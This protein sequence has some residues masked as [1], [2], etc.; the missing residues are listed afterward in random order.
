MKI[1]KNGQIIR[2]TE[3]DL[4]RIVKNVLNEGSGMDFMK[5]DELEELGRGI[6]KGLPSCSEIMT[7]M[8]MEDLQQRLDSFK[9]MK[10]RPVGSI[11][12]AEEDVTL[13]ALEGPIPPSARGVIAYK[14]GKPWCKCGE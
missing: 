12:R 6:S 13:R 11:G 8:A 9:D 1:K 10:E 3:S 4:K 5:K 14:G 2:L 7:K